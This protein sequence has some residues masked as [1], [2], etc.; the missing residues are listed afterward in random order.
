[1]LLSIGSSST[2]QSLCQD[3]GGHS[4]RHAVHAALLMVTGAVLSWIHAY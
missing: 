3:S 4:G 1:M 2:V